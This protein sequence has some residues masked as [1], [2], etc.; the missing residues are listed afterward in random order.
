[1]SKTRCTECCDKL[2]LRSR[3]MPFGELLC[4]NCAK[5]SI[6]LLSHQRQN[7]AMM[8]RRAAYALRDHP[9]EEKIKY[10]LAQYGL[11]GSPLRTEET[12]D[13]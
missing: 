11:H 1:M 9:L 2:F 13:E 12:S 10:L 8:L 3:V 6:E 7:L 5:Q 4:A